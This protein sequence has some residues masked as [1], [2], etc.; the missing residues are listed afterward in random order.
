MQNVKF[1]NPPLIEVVFGVNIKI[2]DFSLVHFGLNWETIKENF[3]II[4][5][6]FGELSLSEDDSYIFNFPTVLYLSSEGNKLIKVTDDYFSYHWRFINEDYQEFKT[7]FEDFMQQWKNF[8][9]WCSTISIKPIRIKGHSLQYI[10]LIDENSGWKNPEDNHRI[11]SFASRET[12]TSL[13]LL[14]SYSCE[15]EFA[16]PGNLGQLIVSSE[17]TNIE[18]SEAELKD[19]MI[20]TLLALSY[21][22][23]DCF[24]EPWFSSAH[25]FI[26]QLFL[27]LTSE[28]VQNKWERVNE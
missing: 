18:K 5:E 19:V 26:I 25:D 9:S 14:K 13:A 20:F 21:Q 10:N 3:P 4:D 6:N 7:L 12:L 28:E 11:F 2:P 15:L 8:E 27:D 1:K 22:E 23:N 17:Q 16:I 24:Q